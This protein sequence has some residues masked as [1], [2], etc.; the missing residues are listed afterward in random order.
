MFVAYKK[1]T[2]NKMTKLNSK[3]TKKFFMINEKKVYGIGYR[4]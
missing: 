1:I 3:K 2:D 4:A